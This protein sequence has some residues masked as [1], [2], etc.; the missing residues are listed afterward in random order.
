MRATRILPSTSASVPT[1][2]STAAKRKKAA[3]L[4]RIPKEELIQYL[5]TLF[6]QYAKWTMK[7]LLEKTK[8]PVVK[9]FIFHLDG[10]LN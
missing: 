4:E 9:S 10:D 3:N 7:G 5:F 2:T 8:Q 6:E 1:L